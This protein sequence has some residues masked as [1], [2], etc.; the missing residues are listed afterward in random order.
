MCLA[1]KMLSVKLSKSLMVLMKTLPIF[2]AA[3][4][5]LGL[6]GAASA[7]PIAFVAPNDAAPHVWS[8]NSND[9]WSS[10][11][12][13][14]FTV[15]Q[16]TMINSVGLFQN[17]NNVTLNYGVYEVSALTGNFNRNAT[18]RSGSRTVT[19]VGLEWIDFS[20]SD[21]NLAVGTDYLVEFSFS[22]NSGQNFFY[23]NGNVAWNQGV[24]Q[25]L[26]GTISN[27][28]DNYVTGGFRVDAAAS[29]D[30][31]EPGSLFLFGAA[32]LG[33]AAARRRRAA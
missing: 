18:L 29:T 30:V 28:F 8:T 14:G 1:R 3:V 6:I 5:S 27:T 4:L 17:L 23:N 22:G 25:G 11:R 10:G 20:F 26:E 19:T 24:F 31:P 21:L 2:A 9:G 32:A 7:A 16:N 33:L 12:G 15:G 13:I